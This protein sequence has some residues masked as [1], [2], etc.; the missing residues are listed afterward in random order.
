MGTTPGVIDATLMTYRRTT[1]HC[2]LLNY[3]RF[4]EKVPRFARFYINC[5][6]LTKF[7]PKIA[8]RVLN[9]LNFIRVCSRVLNSRS[10]R[11]PGVASKAS[12]ASR[13]SFNIQRKIHLGL[14]GRTTMFPRKKLLLSLTAILGLAH[15]LRSTPAAASQET[16]AAQGT[17]E[18]VKAN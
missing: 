1:L 10:L 8:L 11:R 7:S 2:V 9:H 6:L 4:S 18:G 15:H 14:I 5:E 16:Q 3:E 13:V 17:D 12:V